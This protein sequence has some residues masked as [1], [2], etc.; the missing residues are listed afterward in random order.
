[1]TKIP[2]TFEMDGLL[3]QTD[4]DNRFRVVLQCKTCRQWTEMNHPEP[5]KTELVPCRGIINK[6][7][8]ERCGLINYDSTSIKSYRSYSPL[9]DNKRKPKV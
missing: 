2:T 5:L 9:T 7:T 1:M 6:I 4:I 8:G 3:T